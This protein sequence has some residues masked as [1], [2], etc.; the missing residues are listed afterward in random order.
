MIIL[1][2]EI[3]EKLDV[4]ITLLLLASNLVLSILF[5]IIALFKNK[6]EK[7]TFFMLSLFILVT[8][9]FGL[10]Y[11]ILGLSL[12]AYRKN[13]KVDMSDISFGREREDLLISPDKEIEFNY[14]PVE[15][16]I[17]VSDK[18]SLRKLLLNIM[19]K[20]EQNSLASIFGAIKSKD[21]E[22]SHYAASLIMETLSI[23]R[24]NVQNYIETLNENPEDVDFNLKV[25]GYIDET[26]TLNVMNEIEKRTHIYILNDVATI[27]YEK[28][29][30]YMTGEHYLKIIDWLIEVKDYNLAHKWLN[31]S[32]Q[33]RQNSLET[34]KARLHLYYAQNDSVA[35]LE[36]LDGLRESDIIVDQEV[37]D[38]FRFYSEENQ[39]ESV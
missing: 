30:W 6:K 7:P 26:L 9:V 36:T 38:L 39:K 27:L 4:Q 19:L 37:L 16:A 10:S 22:S 28:N 11:I 34:Y 14:V 33:Y 1:R 15:D 8:P 5:F 35:F 29:L 21:S 20:S 13:N 23:A 32:N 31:M 17:A 3:V 2:N 24:I 12:Y 25:F 18:S